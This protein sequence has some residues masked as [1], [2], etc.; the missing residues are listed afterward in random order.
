MDNV[1]HLTLLVVPLPLH[2]LDDVQV[3][4]GVPLAQVCA[5]SGEKIMND[6]L[7]LALAGTGQAR[8]VLEDQFFSIFREALRSICFTF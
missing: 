4:H 6:S 8:Q 1:G 7:V 2:L 3:E 5:Q